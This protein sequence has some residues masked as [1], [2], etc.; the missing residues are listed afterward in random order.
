M[1]VIY[2]SPEYSIPL[3]RS[4]EFKNNT[5]K[6]LTAAYRR[7][8]WRS[9]PWWDN[10]QLARD[11]ENLPSLSKPERDSDHVVLW[12]KRLLS[13]GLSALPATPEDHTIALKRTLCKLGWS[14]DDISRLSSHSCKATLLSFAAKFGMPEQDRRTLG[15]HLERGTATV[16]AHARDSLSHRCGS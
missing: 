1:F 2:A 11:D 16:K 3:Q 7:R 5:T 13:G 6:D 10:Y 14:R 9:F 8:H 4:E 12:P 15:Y